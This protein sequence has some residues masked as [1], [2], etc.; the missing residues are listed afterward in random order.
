MLLFES[1][2]LP[3]LCSLKFRF[4]KKRCKDPRKHTYYSQHGA[5]RVLVQCG[6]HDAGVG[7]LISIR[8]VFDGQT[9]GVH[10]KPD[11]RESEMGDAFLFSLRVI[12][13]FF[14]VFFSTSCLTS[15]LH[16]SSSG[17]SPLSLS[18]VMVGMRD[19]SCLTL[20]SNAALMP[21]WTTLYSGCLRM[22]VGSG[23]QNN[24]ESPHHSL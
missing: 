2:P 23:R 15:G 16:L 24:K 22:R 21:L 13:Q 8:H 9:V 20:H 7:A 5:G 12:P 17:S 18:Q 1:K 19:G 11:D 10:Q 14:F 3:V 6:V 4:P